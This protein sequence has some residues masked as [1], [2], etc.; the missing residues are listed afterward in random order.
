[1]S[2]LLENV[3]IADDTDVQIDPETYQDQTSPAP[4][5][6][7]NYSFKIKKLG[8]RKTKEGEIV[9]RDGQWPVYVLEQ[10]E[11]VE[12]QEF[13]RTVSLFQDVA[14]KPRDRNGVKV[15]QALDLVRACDQTRAIRGLQEVDEA[16]AEF[17]DTGA[18]FRGYLDWN[19]YDGSFAKDELE[20]AD[21]K[22]VKF[23]EMNDEEKKVANDIYGKAK[24]KGMKKFP[25][26]A[27]GRANHIWV[28]PSGDS[29][30]ARAEVTRF[31]PSLETVRL[32]QAA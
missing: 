21:L 2:R 3:T 22:D 8:V 16:L 19:A 18:I 13:A 32:R 7:G 5:E 17:V 14:T 31:Y 6:A 10:V 24:L 1:M 11:I 4:P 26:L 30:E 25:K 27:N 12:P 15:S 20:K 23:A 9:L 29:V 28:G